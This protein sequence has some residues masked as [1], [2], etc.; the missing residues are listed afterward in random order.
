MKNIS[1][2]FGGGSSSGIDAKASINK[3]YY[4]CREIWPHRHDGRNFPACLRGPFQQPKLLH[5]YT[6]MLAGGELEVALQHR[7]GFA[8]EA[9]GVRLAA[10]FQ[11]G[12]PPGIGPPE[13]VAP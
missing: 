5:V 1:H 13:Y 9:F 2:S 3:S 6:G 10:G 7:A 12:G 8:Q 4:F 11:S